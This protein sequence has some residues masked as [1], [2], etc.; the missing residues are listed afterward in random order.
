[1]RPVTVTVTSTGTSAPVGLDYLETPFNG[2]IAIE[3]NGGPTYNVEYAATYPVTSNTTW[4]P[5]A[6]LSGATASAYIGRN[7]PTR[8]VRLNV[9]SVTSAT[10][11]TTMTV[12]QGGNSG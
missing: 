8:F 7:I 2:G 1:M 10:D 11:T 12:L 9:T 5:D 6:T 3:L 4:Y